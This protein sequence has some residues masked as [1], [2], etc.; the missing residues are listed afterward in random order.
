MFGYIVIEVIVSVSKSASWEVRYFN[1]SKSTKNDILR[2]NKL[3]SQ[4]G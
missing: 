2:S 4:M 3:Y 1:F